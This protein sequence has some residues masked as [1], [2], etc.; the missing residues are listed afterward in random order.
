MAKATKERNLRLFISSIVSN[1]VFPLYA[2]QCK[3]LQRRSLLPPSGHTHHT[4]PWCALSLWF[5]FFACLC[6]IFCVAVC[7]NL[8]PCATQAQE[9]VI[10][11]YGQINCFS[12][13]I[14]FA[15]KFRFCFGHRPDQRRMYLICDAHSSYLMALYDDGLLPEPEQHK[16]TKQKKMKQIALISRVAWNVTP[17]VCAH[18]RNSRLRA[19]VVQWADTKHK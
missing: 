5:F 17:H 2:L 12:S 9:C 6:R 11:H 1:P 3:H 15:H 8:G 4:H 16:R 13:P 18:T 19:N 7:A 14:P 10:S